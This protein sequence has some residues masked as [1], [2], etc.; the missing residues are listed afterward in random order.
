[1]KQSRSNKRL[2]T[3]LT[4]AEVEA[5][6][7]QVN[8]RSTTGL[9]NRAM[10]A[11]M[12]GAGLRVSEIVALMPRNVDLKGGMI[13]VN[14]GK[15]GRD[16]VVPVD[17]ETAGW[18]R[19]WAEKRVA[20]GLDGRRRFFCAVRRTQF[21]SEPGK[22]ITVRTVQA[23]VTR[24][25][26]A[27]GIEK[28]VTPHVLR[29]TYATQLLDGGFTIR[30]VQ[31]LLGHSSVSTTMVYIHVNPA[32]LREKIQGASRND[33]QARI[34]AMEEQLSEFKRAAGLE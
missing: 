9:R 32:A 15:G 19:A 6:L 20:L 13:R 33:L 30:E 16:R 10:L 34:A 22:P 25:S 5:L 8:P 4:E 11:A 17:Q 18:L 31:E 12:L 14:N 3:T 1:M 7:A 21:G 29:H 27:A 26:R 23:L 2:P 24:L 28:Q